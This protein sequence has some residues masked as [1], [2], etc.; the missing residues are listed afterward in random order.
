MDKELFNAFLQASDDPATATA[1]AKTL[2]EVGSPE[3]KDE[4]LERILVKI[5]QGHHQSTNLAT[6]ALKLFRGV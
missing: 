5:E 3:Q 2:L 1:F 4:F 6:A